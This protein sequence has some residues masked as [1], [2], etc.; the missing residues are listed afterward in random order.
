MKMMSNLQNFGPQM[1]PLSGINFQ[2]M[3]PGKQVPH[4]KTTIRMP[5]QRDSIS[6][7]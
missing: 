3:D 7:T 5:K 1:T 2:W 6:L 4:T